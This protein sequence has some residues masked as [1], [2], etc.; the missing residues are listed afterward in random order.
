M[1]PITLTP[2]DRDEV[3]RYM[4]TPPEQAGAPLLALVYNCCMQMLAAILG[5]KEA[6]E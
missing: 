1:T 3:L 4:G 2:P 6:K 5:V